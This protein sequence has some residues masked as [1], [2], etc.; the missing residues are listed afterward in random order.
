MSGTT[1][2]RYPYATGMG[3]GTDPANTPGYFDDTAWVS[4]DDM[5]QLLSMLLM[6][7]RSATGSVR[8]WASASMTAIG[9]PLC[10]HAMEFH[11]TIMH[12]FVQMGVQL[13]RSASANHSVY[14]RSQKFVPK[15]WQLSSPFTS[16]RF[17]N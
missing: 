6:N 4:V 12:V 17:S 15:L 9:I 1:T 13:P 11:A 2:W 14:V 7:R 3:F 5:L 10:K 16:L 8:T